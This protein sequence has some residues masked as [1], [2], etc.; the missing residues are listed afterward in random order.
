MIVKGEVFV[1]K[2]SQLLNNVFSAMNRLKGAAG[3]SETGK[4]KGH[5]GGKEG[6]ILAFTRHL[7]CFFP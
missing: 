7:P 2:S 6:E 4:K 3:V 5:E 1:N